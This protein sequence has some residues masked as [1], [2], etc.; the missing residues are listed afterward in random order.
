MGADEQNR[1]EVLAELERLRREVAVLREDRARLLADAEVSAKEVLD[2]APIM[3]MLLDGEG[4][5]RRANRAACRALPPGEAVEGRPVGCLLDCRHADQSRTDCG[6]TED[7]EDCHLRRTIRRTLTDGIGMTGEEL[8]LPL[9]HEEHESCLLAS[10]SI[11]HFG[12]EDLV[13]LCLEDISEQ[14]RAEAHARTT[15]RLLRESQRVEAVG[16][17]AGGVAHDFNNLL[18]A[19]IGH[20]RLAMEGMDPEEPI[21]SRLDG[22]YW[23]GKRA[24][25]LTGQ[26]LAFSRRQMLQKKVRDLNRMVEE[27]A[28]MLGRLIGQNVSVVL[29]LDE[30]LPPVEVDAN[31]MTQVLLNLIVNAREAMPEGGEVTLSTEVVTITERARYTM[32]D[33]RPGDF[34][35]LT[36][37]DTGMGMSPEILSK[38]FE[39]FFSTK[40]GGSGMGL[41]VVHGLVRQ[42]E[43]WIHVASVPGRG[44]RVHIYLPA[45]ERPGPPDPVEDTGR[46]LE[47]SRR[48]GER[49]LVV[50]DE[51]SLLELAT[52]ILSEKGFEVFAA[53]NA[54]DPRALFDREHGRF[55]LI[56]SD[57]VLPDG[58]GVDLTQS[59]LAARPGL[60]V[61]LTSGYADHRSRWDV[62]QERGLDFMRKPY[63]PSELLQRVRELLGDAD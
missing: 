34:V 8:R 63:T 48:T 54:R 42:H 5:V 40:E 44:T 21:W 57:V 37:K 6:L 3:I 25:S 12:S 60:P 38:I 1:G 7:C 50:E 15:E 13:M 41:P 29:D 28:A 10:T 56:F 19:I 24:A 9:G 59:F 61:L 4:R 26:L 52:I 45:S 51:E 55:D 17:L 49:V 36:V 18:T 39:P 11:L 58:N 2:A 22:I 32:P 62:I 20:A 35:R 47:D 53:P 27:Q 14:R 23:A 30:V 31:Q 16:R 43:G 33:A 46:Q